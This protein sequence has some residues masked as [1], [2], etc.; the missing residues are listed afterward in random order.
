M[1]PTVTPP[2][3]PVHPLEVPLSDHPENTILEVDVPILRVE[4]YAGAGVDITAGELAVERIKA[5][6]QSTSRPEVIGGLGA[7]GA[8]FAFDAGKYERP[9]LVSST[10]TVGTKAVVARQARRLNTIGIDLVAMSVDDIACHGAEP[11]F[12][13]DCIMVGKLDPDE[14]DQLVEGV[15]RG[16]LTAGC[17]L[18]GGEMAELPGVIER[19]KFDLVG[20][21]VGVVERDRL[22]TGE[23]VKPGDRLV[24]LPSDGLRCNGY[25]LARRILLERDRLPL[26]GPAW[27][28]AEHSLGEELLKPSIIYAPAITALARELPVKGLAHITGG[29]L[30]DNLA[31]ALSPY[32]DARVQRKS[33][34]AP[35]IFSEIESRGVSRDEM[36]R[37]FN[38]GIGMVA[39]VSPEDSDRCHEILRAAGHGSIDIGEVV[40]GNKTVDVVY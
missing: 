17:A 8:L 28:G 32:C 39:I 24:G 18:V 33:W 14:V 13:L 22:V 38:L 15:V 40:E 16:C 20:F 36:E 11:L 12:F 35:R 26:Q 21:A 29:G 19:G 31:R 9:V 10:D 25:S 3:P 1:G 37:T 5:K 34:E 27:P 30:R 7:F 6:V 4:T 2:Q 23:H